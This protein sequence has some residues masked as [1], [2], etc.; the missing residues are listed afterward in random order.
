MAENPFAYKPNFSLRAFHWLVFIY[1]SQ[2]AGDGTAP[3]T[4][5][6]ASRAL[7][8]LQ[9]LVDTAIRVLSDRL[10]GKICKYM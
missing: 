1:F 5:P 3:T 4:N 7:S 2:M 8:S 9:W 6:P 10:H